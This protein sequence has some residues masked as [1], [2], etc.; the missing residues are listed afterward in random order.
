M[1]LVGQMTHPYRHSY[2]WQIALLPDLTYLGAAISL[3]STNVGHID[4]GLLQVGLDIGAC[5]D[6]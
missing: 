1:P 5:D 3:V 4:I 2:S 6:T